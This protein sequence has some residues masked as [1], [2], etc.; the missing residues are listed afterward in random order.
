MKEPHKQYSYIIFD[1]DGTLVDTCPDLVK[2]VQYI[3]KKYQ[4]EEKP[5][6]FIR[7]C[8]GGGARNILLRALGT[9]KSALIDSELLPLF[10]EY[11]TAHCADTSKVY[12]GVVDILDYYQQCNKRL[13][14][15]TF[16]IRSATEKIFQKFDLMKYFDMIVTADDVDNP[17]P[18]PDCVLKILDFYGC[19]KTEAILVGDTKT[20]YLTGRNA[21]IDV[22][23]VTYG[24][25]EKSTL[26]NFIP[27][28]LIDDI[29]EIKSVI[30]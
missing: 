29:T 16:K 11:Y 28:Y 2:T 8:I 24:Y 30:K 6:E 1:L 23:M 4:F 20:D 15:A 14:V 7:G 12:P 22:C 10:S 25:G 19:S 9:D 13:A 21:G 17:K 26:Q 27:L 3:I 5:N 18:E